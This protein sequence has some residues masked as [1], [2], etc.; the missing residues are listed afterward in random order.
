MLLGKVT[1]A[2][3][4]ISSQTHRGKITSQEVQRVVAPA[5]GGPHLRRGPWAGAGTWTLASQETTALHFFTSLVGGAGPTCIIITVTQGER[6][7]F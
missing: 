3:A 6:V 1:W 7:R 2:Q 4:R 5:S